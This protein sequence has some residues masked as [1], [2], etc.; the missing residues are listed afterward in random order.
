MDTPELYSPGQP[1]IAG[2]GHLTDIG[3]VGTGN[4]A[5]ALGASLSRSGVR[6]RVIAGRDRDKAMRAAEYVGAERAVPIEAIASDVEVVLI[7]VSDHAIGIVGRQIADA[8]LVPAVALHTCGS[9]G[10][11]V[12]QPLRD[13]GSATGVLHP[14]QTIPSPDRGVEALSHCYYAYCGDAAALACAQDLIAR[15]GG[16]SLHVEASRWALYHAAAVLSINFHV[17]LVAS[18]LELW[19]QAGI[20]RQDAL[21]AL[22]PIIRA[23]VENLLAMGPEKA[24]TGPIQRGDAATVSRHLRSIQDAP[25]HIQNLY[26]AAARQT[27]AL[28]RRAGLSEEAAHAVEAALDESPVPEGETSE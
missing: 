12:L 1:A 13:A 14:L 18:S 25:E 20:S 15:L 16:N 24:L 26:R 10:P 19:E 2:I 3:I 17:T 8:R 5:Q 21:A 11:E 28:A 6:V 22:S 23:G 9:I 4:V 27:V 7:A